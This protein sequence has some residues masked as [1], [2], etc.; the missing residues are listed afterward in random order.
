[1]KREI[2]TKIY[3]PNSYL[4]EGNK[5]YKIVLFVNGSQRDLKFART[6]RTA[7]ETRDRM[8]LKFKR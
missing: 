5:S 2:R 4:N 6:L 3:K 8:K 7:R 1:M